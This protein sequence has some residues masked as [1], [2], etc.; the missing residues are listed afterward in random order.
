MPYVLLPDLGESDITAPLAEAG[1]YVFMPISTGLTLPEDAGD[2]TVTPLLTTSEAA[3][4]KIAGYGLE[5]YEKEE[6]DLDGPLYPGGLHP[7]R[8]G[9]DGMAH[10]LL[11]PG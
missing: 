9:A 11:L 1:Y 7:G 3:F 4:S 6:G 2:A 10:L 5:T 8:G